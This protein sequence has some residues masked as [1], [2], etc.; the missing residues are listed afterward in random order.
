MNK[1]EILNECTS[2]YRDIDKCITNLV[3]A[4][5]NNDSSLEQKA[6]FEMEKLMIGTLQDLTVI[7]D[8]IE[9]KN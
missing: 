8:Y 2:L 9:N 3:K 4:R 5:L 7:M 6:Y 1:N